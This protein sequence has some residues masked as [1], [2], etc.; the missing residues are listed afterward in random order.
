MGLNLPIASSS[1]PPCM[2]SPAFADPY[3]VVG[4][5]SNAFNTS[6]EISFIAAEHISDLLRKRL[7][8]G[9]WIDAL[10]NPTAKLEGVFHP[11]LNGEMRE[12]V[13]DFY[14]KPRTIIFTDIY[15]A[16]YP[17]TYT[18]KGF[19]QYFVNYFGAPACLEIVGGV[20]IQLLGVEFFKEYLETMGIHG[21]EGQL[22]PE[23]MGGLLKAAND[24]DLR[25]H[26]PGLDWEGMKYAGNV[27]ISFFTHLF[28]TRYQFPAD[29][30]T[31]EFVRSRFFHKFYH[32]PKE[33]L[34][35]TPHS[36]LHN[37]TV[38]PKD[39]CRTEICLTARISRRHLFVS[40]A[41]AIDFT[42]LMF[43]S[44]DRIFLTSDLSSM[45]KA[46]ICRLLGVVDAD[47][48][49]GIDHMGW[50]LYISQLSRGKICLKEDVERELTQTFVDKLIENKIPFSLGALIDKVYKNHHLMS[51]EGNSHFLKDSLPLYIFNALSVL[52]KYLTDEKFDFFR[53]KI[54]EGFTVYPQGTIYSALAR[55][56]KSEQI[57][58]ELLSAF[59]QIMVLNVYMDEQPSEGKPARVFLRNHCG[60]AALQM[61]IFEGGKSHT[62]LVPLNLQAGL[63]IMRHLDAEVFSGLGCLYRL[64]KPEN[65]E[66]HIGNRLG[67][68]VPFLGQDLSYFASQAC[69][70]FEMMVPSLRPL[71]Y[72]FMLLLSGI[73]GI[74]F[75][76]PQ[77]LKKFPDL[78][79]SCENVDQ[80]LHL[81]KVLLQL[82]RRFQ[83]ELMTV[84][85][86]NRLIHLAADDGLSR[87][88]F[89]EEVSLELARSGIGVLHS[90]AFQLFKESSSFRLPDFVEG[91]C[92]QGI[93]LACEALN[94]FVV[95]LEISDEEVLGALKMILQ[96]SFFDPK[97]TDLLSEVFMVMFRRNDLFLDR[98][99]I[100]MGLSFL[101]KIGV[102]S[103]CALSDTIL[104]RAQ[105][106]A[107][108]PIDHVCFLNLWE[109]Y[110][111]HLI[112][113]GSDS[114]LGRLMEAYG[115]GEM[116]REVLIR[117]Q[118]SMLRNTLRSKAPLSKESLDQFAMLLQNEEWLNY[119]SEMLEYF[120]LMMS[121]A[122]D[123]ASGKSRQGTRNHLV[124]E[125]LTGHGLEG[126]FDTFPDT[127]FGALFDL[128]G[129]LSPNERKIALHKVISGCLGHLFRC[130]CAASKKIEF[131]M[132]IIRMLES[133]LPNSLLEDVLRSYMVEIGQLIEVADQPML[134]IRFLK[135]CDTYGV[136]LNDAPGNLSRCLWALE[137]GL[138][139]FS[140]QDYVK[141]MRRLLGN[142]DKIDA[143][144]PVKIERFLRFIFETSRFIADPQDRIFWLKVL[145]RSPVPFS[146]PLMF[147]LDQLNLISEG[148]DLAAKRQ[149]WS[150]VTEMFE[151]RGVFERYPE[152]REWAYLIAVRCLKQTDSEACLELLSS[153]RPFVTA[154]LGHVM[155]MEFIEEFYLA[156]FEGVLQG[157]KAPLEEGDE[158]KLLKLYELRHDFLQRYDV[159]SEALQ[160]VD[161]ELV[162]KF[163][164][165]KDPQNYE[166]L[167]EILLKFHKCDTDRILDLYHKL[168]RRLPLFIPKAS[169][170]LL[171]FFE[172]ITKDLL[173]RFGN[174]L[175]LKL[176]FNVLQN[177]FHRRVRTI[178]TSLVN[179]IQSLERGGMTFNLSPIK[180]SIE[181]FIK[182]QILANNF[183]FVDLILYSPL[184]K[185]LLE[186]N[187]TYVQPACSSSRGTTRKGR[188]VQKFKVAVKP[189]MPFVSRWELLRGALFEKLLFKLS[190]FQSLEGLFEEDQLY[191]A[192][193]DQ[194]QHLINTNDAMQY[195]GLLFDTMIALAEKS[196]DV[197]KFRH[198]IENFFEVMNLFMFNYQEL[199]TNDILVSQ[200]KETSQAVPY[201]IPPLQFEHFLKPFTKRKISDGFFIHQVKYFDIVN[202]FCQKLLTFKFTNGALAL[203]SFV[204]RLCYQIF[205]Y[206]IVNFDYLVKE[207]KVVDNLN[208]YLLFE[209]S[210]ANVAVYDHHCLYCK[211]LFSLYLNSLDLTTPYS[212][213]F[214]LLAIRPG[215]I[216]KLKNRPGFM[217]G[218]INILKRL[219][220]I[221]TV[222]SL[223]IVVTILRFC[224][225]DMF[226]L[227]PKEL[228]D[229]CMKILEWCEANPSYIYGGKQ[230][231]KNF[232]EAFFPKE[233]LNSDIKTNFI[234]LQEAIISCL[235]DKEIYKKL[236]PEFLRD[237]LDLCS[238]LILKRYLSGGYVSHLPQF[239]VALMNLHDFADGFGRGS[240]ENYLYATRK[241]RTLV[242]LFLNPNPVNA[243]HQSE[244]EAIVKEVLQ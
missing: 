87:E 48:T 217:P 130:P 199:V 51:G 237:H 62:L 61:T 11:T 85:F 173:Q 66:I 186:E 119:K 195:V 55:L 94:F 144:D 138:V 214:G 22:C 201:M 224:S 20:V 53:K 110:I 124:I 117:C 188:G 123:A 39:E 151:E 100:S 135:V 171:A 160:K 175:D 50:P 34:E 27:A 179:M 76:F 231:F 226:L 77:F 112:Q 150:L 54:L 19:F 184:V 198:R 165:C 95:Q 1:Q 68:Y 141:M 215:L 145:I 205:R 99:F 172:V 23:L 168:V 32:F 234:K 239:K 177:S 37:L 194:I 101:E 40:D 193:V 189:K 227:Q 103:K 70:L 25:C 63:E 98:Q 2:V 120:N 181:E 236:L 223:S 174:S 211:H 210:F 170:R 65:S 167:W 24:E 5:S 218:V 230:L 127:A 91:L 206:N 139:S 29:K 183:P 182:N 116:G 225:L 220:E 176:I 30:N 17:L 9:G 149:V 133:Q 209:F 134:M 244:L 73:D 126:F 72:D 190:P 202:L 56:L 38:C 74:S 88:K 75:P 102:R 143:E 228:H 216:M 69:E 232:T 96:I 43:G 136:L 36:S 187:P 153:D 203:N 204:H 109:G 129:K 79:T 106:V 46:I 89:L 47:R 222:E 41:L 86:E 219:I 118:L 42:S 166:S 125:L 155:T 60:G 92:P 122:L 241:I 104:S 71:V 191:D 178:F 107:L 6:E 12:R 8:D 15:H 81:C 10:G 207:S 13:W 28:V 242:G 59:V 162:E 140:F 83:G 233:R 35:L 185:D 49:E 229:L 192:A 212:F 58:F 137:E 146:I 147:I 163:Y 196:G 90:M 16:T 121:K 18:L 131:L 78:L 82:L 80:R 3:N 208:N 235:L 213:P 142:V 93:Q 164:L 105:N 157:V 169:D 159:Y 240:E 111:N 97:Q 180:S 108:D 221:N 7:V 115:Q 154:R 197:E 57:S 128:I 114:E 200:D 26:F 148:D 44:K 156:M 14:V 45:H 52:R 21:A 64:M 113:Q 31:F 4:Q 238:L 161:M 67:D 243:E 152:A 84:D 158:V 33:P 132:T